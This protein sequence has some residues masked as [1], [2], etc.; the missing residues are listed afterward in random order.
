LAIH[1][2]T[3]FLIRAAVGGSEESVL[4]RLRLVKGEAI[5]IS[6]I[7]WAEFLCGPVSVTAMEDAAELLG[8]PAPLDGRGATLAAHLFNASGRR[9]G[10]L[11]DCMIAAIAIRAGAALAT[12]NAADFA[13]L[14]PFGLT[15]LTPSPRT[16]PRRATSP[17]RD[18]P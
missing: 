3:S 8:E 18:A 16:S 11:A 15:V 1:L 6:S 7:A 2:D 14:T 4:L 10:S 5:G 17:S 12:S 9:R 13:R